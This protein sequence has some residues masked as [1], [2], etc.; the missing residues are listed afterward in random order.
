MISC[1]SK[2]L[3]MFL[4]I[5]LFVVREIDTRAQSKSQQTAEFNA[6]TSIPSAAPSPAPTPTEIKLGGVTF[7]GS[8]RT[9]FESWDWFETGAA[10]SS[11]NFGA[12]TLRLS[13]SQQKEKF[14]WQIEGAF[15]LLINPP[16]DAI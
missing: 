1:I 5:C 11:Y 13:L 6:P 2:P 12:A 8:V 16:E 14:G 4:L 15:P 7:S 3:F 9:R 10:N